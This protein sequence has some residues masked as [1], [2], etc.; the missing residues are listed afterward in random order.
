MFLAPLN[1]H[2][3]FVKVFSDERIARQFL[4]DFLDVKIEEFQVLK[5]KHSITD[6]AAAVEFDYRCKI[7]DS[8]III[9]MQQWYKPDIVQRFFL[10]HALNTGL[11]LEELPLK[12]IDLP[13]KIKGPKRGRDYR[14]LEPV[15]TLI[16]MVM[17]S[18][19][20]ERDYISYLM[21]PEALVDFLKDDRL[22]KEPEIKKLLEERKKLLEILNN[23]SKNLD[24]LP[25]NRLIFIFQGNIV[26]NKEL[27]K[28][29]KWFEFAEKT[30]DENNDEEDFKEYRGDEIF[31]EMI[32]RLR[33]DVLTT[34]DF[35]YIED[36]K[37]A[38]EEIERLER[39]FY[40]D[41]KKE[42]REEGR[43]IGREEG[44]EEGREIGREIGR[45]EGRKLGREEG[46]EKGL[47]DKA[48]E[49]A[50]MMK[51]NREPVEK[52]ILY[53]GLSADEIQEL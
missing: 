47:K 26:K 6:D 50:R 3:F 49:T 35:D 20:F 25:K 53:T 33:K 24:F 37:T 27:K 28:Y 34:E 29:E 7:Q 36:Q 2:R 4:E 30:R 48:V 13:T 19:N 46:R 9:D 22:W 12:R 8:H 5:E 23:K 31:C 17:D 45:E 14:V 38:L 40:E 52:I 15:Y 51:E 16:W 18:L 21:A 41:G 32:R 43:E 1:Y 44:R 11:Q 42:G 10:Y 39:G